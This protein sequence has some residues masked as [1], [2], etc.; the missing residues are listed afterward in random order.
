[1][2]AQTD[3][4]AVAAT[5]AEILR[6][7]L[8]LFS[9]YGFQKTNIG[10]IAK[11]A[12][13]S[14]GNIYRFYRNKAAIGLAVVRSYFDLAEAAMAQALALSASETAEARIAT[15]IETGV[16]H[17]VG[18]LE[19]NPKIVE[20]AEFLCEDDE[21][22]ALLQVHIAWKRERIAAEIE[23]GVY[24]G[25]LQA[26][27]PQASATAILLGLNAFWTPMTLAR[28]WDRATILPE[29]RLVLDLMFKGLRA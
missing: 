8:D 23:R 21:G 26:D 14:P 18:E 12:G 5:R 17:L 28:W 9:H 25:T 22:W 2:A 19:E 24:D 29:L 4:M 7:A 11:R 20:L 6:H 1:M 10:D 27:D 16:S 3:D 15:M 13:M